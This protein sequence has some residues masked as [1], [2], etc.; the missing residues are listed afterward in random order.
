MARGGRSH[1]VTARWDGGLKTTVSVRGFS[2][3]VDEPA[4]AGGTDAGP[5]PTEYFL[6][7]LASCYAL[8]VAWE[9]KKRDIV[10]PDLEVTAQGDYDGPCFARLTLAV[11][12][13]LPD[14]V[15]EPLLKSASRVCYVSRTL[16]INPPIEVRRAHADS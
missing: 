15:L 3:V 12:S 11:T 6:G 8:A 5:M 10:V 13:S 1:E 4:S 2:F 7:S 16:D 9:A 14:D